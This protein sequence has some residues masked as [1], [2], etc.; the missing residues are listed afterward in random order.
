MSGSY[1]YVG[2]DGVTYEGV[3]TSGLCLKKISLEN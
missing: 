2:P 1:S 3:Y